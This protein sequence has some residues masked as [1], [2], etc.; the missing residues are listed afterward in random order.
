MIARPPHRRR[1]NLPR[2]PNYRPH[3][4]A[5]EERLP[6]GDALL[7]TALTAVWLETRPE[8]LADLT[9]GGSPGGGAASRPGQACPATCLSACFCDSLAGRRR[10]YSDRAGIAWPRRRAYDDD[11]YPCPES[12]RQRSAKSGGHV[13]MGVAAYPRG[14]RLRNVQPIARRKGRDDGR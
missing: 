5:L 4:R 10:R 2:R 11:L 13:V 7:G 6:L 14:D 12:G 8:P 9:P 1:T 3:V